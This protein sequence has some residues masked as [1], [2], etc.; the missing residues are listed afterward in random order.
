MPWPWSMTWRSRVYSRSRMVVAMRARISRA[1][2][3][4]AKEREAFADLMDE[5]GWDAFVYKNEF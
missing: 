4:T 5:K 2:G 1:G 3:D